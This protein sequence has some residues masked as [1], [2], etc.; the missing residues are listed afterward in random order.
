MKLYDAISGVISRLVSNR[1]KLPRWLNRIIDDVAKNPRG[2]FARIADSI[3]MK[4]EIK[5]VA[6]RAPQGRKTVFIGPTNYSGQ[7]Y[8]WARSLEKYG[9]PSKNLEVVLPGG[10]EFPADSRV[11]VSSYNRSRTWQGEQFKAV[12]Q[13]THVLVEAERPLFGGLYQWNLKREINT[14]QEHHVNVALMCHGTDVRSPRLHRSLTQWSPYLTDSELSRQHQREVDRNLALIYELDLPTFV[15]TPDLLIDLPLASW[16]PVVV[17]STRWTRGEIP[18]QNNKPV[19]VHIPSMGMVKGTHLIE[20]SLREL[21]EQGLIEY[22]AFSGITAEQ[23]PAIIQAADIVL[24]QFR[25]GSYGVAAVEA[26]FTGRL[27]VGHIAPEVRRLVLESTGSE[28]PIIEADPSNLVRVII[29]I[30]LAPHTYQKIGESGYEFARKV[31]D[32]QY[33]ATVLEEKWLNNS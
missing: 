24:D 10:F 33:S 7:G 6:T 8:S 17:D 13:F 29:D 26:M 32:G 16:C 20:Q 5:P 28:L 30:L 12:S 1:S 31:H 23:M 15:S 22:R 25:I 11:S 18:L 19:V 3:L 2:L 14:L 4:S 21:D 9:I 27:V